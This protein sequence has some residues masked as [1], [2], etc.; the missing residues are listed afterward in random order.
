MHTII[1]LT[2]VFYF[3]Q[4]FFTFLLCSPPASHWLRPNVLEDLLFHWGY[5]FCSVL[6]WLGKWPYKA[7]LG[8]KKWCPCI[9]SFSLENKSKSG[10]LIS[11]LYSV[12]G[13]I[14]HLYLLRKLVMTFPRCGHTLLCKISG[15][16]SSKS[17]WFFIHFSVQFLHVVRIIHCCHT[18]F[19]Q[20]SI[21]HDDS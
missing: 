13:N 19:T 7:L 1:L 11:G 16:F 17:G 6:G 21:C 3:W 12:W 10:G 2:C 15:P 14:S 18:C 8:R 5:H 9:G 4:Y 20:D